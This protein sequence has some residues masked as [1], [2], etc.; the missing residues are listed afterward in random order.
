MKAMGSPSDRLRCGLRSPSIEH[1]ITRHV[2]VHRAASRGGTFQFGSIAIMDRLALVSISRLSGRLDAG[3]T[4]AEELTRLFLDRAEGVG[5]GL[6]CYITLC[7]DT[8]LLDAR[9]ASKRAAAK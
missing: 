4:N 6:N 8:A 3:E 9:A 1:S 5:R 2:A 7:R